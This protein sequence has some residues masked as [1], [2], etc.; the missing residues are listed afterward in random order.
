[1]VNH[2]ITFY[3]DLFNLHTSAIYADNCS[4]VEKTQNID[5]Y[6]KWV[7]NGIKERPLANILYIDFSAYVRFCHDFTH[8]FYV[9]DNQ[10]MSKHIQ[11]IAKK[12]HLYIISNR[13]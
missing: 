6:M 5:V 2:F 13:A 10:K 11:D 12:N 9:R 1:M 8:Q 3:Y 4:A 7:I